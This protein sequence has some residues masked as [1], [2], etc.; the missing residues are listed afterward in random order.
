MKIVDEDLLQV[1]FQKVSLFIGANGK[2][3]GAKAINLRSNVDSGTGGVSAVR[4]RCQAI[5]RLN[6][7]SLHAYCAFID[8]SI[9]RVITI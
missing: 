9:L 1:V 2:A 7:V 6:S 4:W 5:F 8:T 3:M